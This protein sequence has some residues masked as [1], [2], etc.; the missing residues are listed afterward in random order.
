MAS[1]VDDKITTELDNYGQYAYWAEDDYEPK[2]RVLD[3]VDGMRN[4]KTS[5]KEIN[6]KLY[7]KVKNG[8]WNDLLGY[9]N[10]LYAG[11]VSEGDYRANGTSGG[12]AT[13]ILVQLLK[14]KKVDGVICAV[15]TDGEDGVLFKYKVLKTA[16][17]VKKA[18]KTKYYP[19][20]LSHVLKYVKEHDGKYA[21][22][23]IPSFIYELR[24]LQDVDQV[25]RRRI[26]YTIGLM[27]G[28][29]KSTKY[30]EAMAWQHGIKPGDLKEFVFRVKN[31]DYLPNQHLAKMRGKIGKTE[32]TIYRPLKDN[33]VSNW[34]L[35]FFKVAFS[36]YVD[37]IYNMTA[38]VTLGDAWLEKYL[39]D[40]MGNNIV[41]VRNPEIQKII[42]DGIAKGVLEVDEVDEAT[43]IRTQAGAIHHQMDEAAYRFKKYGDNSLRLYKK[44]ANQEDPKALKKMVQKIRTD[45]SMKSHQY[46]AEAVA[47]DDWTYFEK[48]MKKYV[49]GY[50]LVYKLIHAKSLGIKGSIDKA[51]GKPPRRKS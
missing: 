48:K 8:Q 14:L 39:K 11:H 16:A 5:E 12:F 44:Y 31:E 46:Y 40:K 20:E 22:V 45:I 37:D 7:G 26:K 38:D 19:M 24:L 47:R 6:K 3:A 33:F 51:L 29:Q 21:I 17:D 18:A 13:W 50:N 36:D 25:F 1:V 2:K 15:A 30:A 9:H 41:I 35:G 34:P 4:K 23:G 49:T 28:H 32:K 27:C 10:G 42:K 43:A